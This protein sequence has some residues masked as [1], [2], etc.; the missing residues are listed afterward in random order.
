MEKSFASIPVH[1]GRDRPLYDASSRGRSSDIIADVIDTL[2]DRALVGVLAE[3][4]D[5]SGLPFG[6]LTLLVRLEAHY[7]TA[8]GA[9]RTLVAR[10]AR[11]T[12]L[13]T[14]ILNEIIE[15]PTRTE[16]QLS[17]KLSWCEIH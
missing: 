17:E 7:F 9:F 16:S 3:G 6:R 11:R 4:S 5:E 10:A 2:F 13:P 1:P 12:P 14:A 15:E 8:T